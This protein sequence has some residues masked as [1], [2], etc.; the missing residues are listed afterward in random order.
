MHL[1]NIDILVIHKDIVIHRDTV[2]H[3]D[4][5]IRKD[6]VIHK[7][8]Q[9]VLQDMVTELLSLGKVNKGSVCSVILLLLLPE[10][11]PGSNIAELEVLETLM[12]LNPSPLLC[13]FFF[14]LRIDAS[15][16]LCFSLRIMKEMEK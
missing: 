1:P 14:K 8:I 15:L 5:L 9:I 6:T 2:I 13:K 16:V 11:C 7:G 10:V 12:P 4:I 3:K